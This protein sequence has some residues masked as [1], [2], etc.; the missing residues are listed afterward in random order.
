M[1]QTA[2]S[3]DAVAYRYTVGDAPETIFGFSEEN[4]EIADW[5]AEQGGLEPPLSRKELSDG[6]RR[7]CW[8]FLTLKFVR[9]EAGFY[10]V[11]ENNS[12]TFRKPRRPRD[13][14]FCRWCLWIGF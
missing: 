13:R 7:C 2:A 6:K 1:Q 5:L 3:G 4:A 12:F 9:N 8:R 10:F 14:L 11:R